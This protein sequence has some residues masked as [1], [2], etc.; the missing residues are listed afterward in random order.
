[1]IGSLMHNCV[2]YLDEVI[3]RVDQST[4]QQVPYLTS[5]FDFRVT[6]QDDVDRKD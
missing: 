5:L 6:L 2:T 4:K 1:M 3:R